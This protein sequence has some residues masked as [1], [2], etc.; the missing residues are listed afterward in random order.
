MT[1]GTRKDPLIE[2]GRCGALVR[3]REFHD[4]HHDRQ[5]SVVYGIIRCLE[6]VMLND[7]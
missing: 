5:D 1:I 4:E 2:C 3:D 7:G 6:K